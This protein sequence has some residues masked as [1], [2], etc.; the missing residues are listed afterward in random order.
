MSSF[1]TSLG[2]PI[3]PQKPMFL[4]FFF[5]P[6]IREQINHIFLYRMDGLEVGLKYLD[7]FMKPNSYTK[8]DW[9]W[10]ISKIKIRINNWDF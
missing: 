2:M 5:D 7:Y 4:H 1:C 3:T 6:G 10:L 9:N 8:E